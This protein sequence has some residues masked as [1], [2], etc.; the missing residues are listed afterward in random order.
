MFA[1]ARKA[2]SFVVPC[3]GPQC[4]S[5]TTTKRA[6]VEASSIRFAHRRRRR[7]IGDD[8]DDDYD[9]MSNDDDETT[10]SARTTTTSEK[11]SR[12]KMCAMAASSFAA[13][14]SI[15]P[16]VLFA[17]RSDDAAWAF[18]KPPRILIYASIHH[19]GYFARPPG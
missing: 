13:L 1:C 4:W 12:R 10:T 7:S 3:R 16:H 14:H 6:R 17:K 5:E 11:K 8:D 2:S 18:T 15:L 9:L 19:A